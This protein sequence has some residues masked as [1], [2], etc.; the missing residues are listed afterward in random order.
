MV[1]WIPLLVNLA[2]DLEAVVEWLEKKKQA[3]IESN[4][5]SD[6]WLGRGAPDRVIVF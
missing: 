4:K 6:L 1:T 5:D 3:A 2:M